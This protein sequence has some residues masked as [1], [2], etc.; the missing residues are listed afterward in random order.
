VSPKI[1][2]LGGTVVAFAGAVGVTS[3][4][5]GGASLDG[6]SVSDIIDY[7]S[8]I[9]GSAALLLGLIA[10]L[11]GWV[12]P[13]YIYDDMKTQRDTAQ[14]LAKSGTDIAKTQ[15]VTTDRATSAAHETAG[16]ATQIAAI[17]R[18]QQQGTSSGGA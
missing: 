4:Q 7:G 17:L 2:L 9:T 12:V 16:L 15:S 13:R 8:R 1:E 6:I 18:Q 3:L 14:A 5:A 10:F 11:R